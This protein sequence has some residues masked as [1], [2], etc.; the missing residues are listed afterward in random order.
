M[1]AF[2]TIVEKYVPHE[3]MFMCNSGGFYPNE[4]YF[5]FNEYGEISSGDYPIR[6]QKSPVSIGDIAKFIIVNDD[7]FGNEEI[8]KLLDE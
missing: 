6:E 1:N 5:W 4:R 8:R 3:I 7:D 2:K